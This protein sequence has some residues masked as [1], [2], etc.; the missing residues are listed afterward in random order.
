MVTEND[1]L[2]KGHPEKTRYLNNSKNNYDFS[3]IDKFYNYF[4]S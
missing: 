3:E 4:V 1:Q 2:L